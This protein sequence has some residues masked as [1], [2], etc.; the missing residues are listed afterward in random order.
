MTKSVVDDLR[1]L[2]TL[3]EELREVQESLARGPRLAKAKGQFVAQKGAEVETARQKQRSLRMTADQKTLQLKS[4]EAKLSDLQGK[5][6][7]AASNREYTILSSQIEAD[8]VAKSVLEDEILETLEMVEVAGVEIKKLEQELAAAKAEEARALA[9]VAAAEAGLK[10]REAKLK[11]SLPGAEAFITGEAKSKYARMVQAYGVS[12]MAEVSGNTCSSCYMSLPQQTLVQLRSGEIAF[13]KSCG[14][15]LF[16]G[17]AV[18][19]R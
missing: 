2:H 14:R 17:V 3:L 9:D 7:A 19:G 12:S 4:G 13:C 6:N 16:I 1:H 18:D 10:E 8:T 11:A 5:L 15:L